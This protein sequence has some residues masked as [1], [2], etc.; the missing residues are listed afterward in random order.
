[1]S[2]GYEAATSSVA[3]FDRADRACLAVT[4]RAPGRMLKGI[5]T[6]SIPA[7][8]E[9][10]EDAFLRGLA[11]YTA[12]LT[13]NG[14]MITDGRLWLRGSEDTEGFILDIPT[15]GRERLLFHLRKF[16]PPRMASVADLAGEVRVASVVGPDA[17]DRLASTAFRGRMAPAELS[18]LDEGAWREVGQSL[19]ERLAVVRWRDVWPEAFDVLGATGAIG[20]LLDELVASGATRAEPEVWTTL[21]IEAGRPAFGVEMD[22]STIPVEAGIHERAIDYT[23]G[24]Y[25]GQEVIV[26]IRD[27]GHVNRNLRLV[28]L[29]ETDPPAP[30]TELFAPDSAKPAA[31][32]ASSVRSP[33]FGETI[34]LAYVR[35]G[36]EE[37]DLSIAR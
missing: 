18:G 22:E 9:R 17:A 20:G 4:G 12:A 28:F 1:M 11:S 5:L 15:S 37:K 27:R 23:K 16:L 33:R 30:G 21:R 8:P 31:T 7:E 32:V 14:K 35:R 24:C 26:R 25:T 10:G 29:G 6:G 34:A 3:V 36:S 19:E 2:V 13:L